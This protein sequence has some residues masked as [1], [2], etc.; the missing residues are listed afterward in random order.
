MVVFAGWS[1]CSLLSRLVIPLILEKRSWPSFPLLCFRSCG[2]DS[3]RV[4]DFL[5]STVIGMLNIEA[6]DTNRCTSSS[7]FLSFRFEC[8][9][10]CRTCSR[11]AQSINEWTHTPVFSI[12]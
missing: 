5:L 1:C 7:S 11:L 12:L 9:T 3:V 10:T 2:V 6:I 8:N 4:V